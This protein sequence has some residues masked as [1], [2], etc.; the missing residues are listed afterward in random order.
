MAKK[1][2]SKRL[3]HILGLTLVLLAVLTGTFFLADFISQS[4]TAQR[5]IATMGY[6]GVL[7]VAFISGISAVSP[8]PPGA[9]VPLF[10]S[11]GLWLPLII[12]MLI[13]GTTLADF[14]GYF[15][16]KYSIGF[17][18]KHYPELY[19]RIQKLDIDNKII[20]FSFVI[21]YAAL[22]PFPNEAFLIPLAFI[23]VPLKRFV[24][25]LVLGTTVYHVLTAYGAEGLF[26]LFF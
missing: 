1:S 5:V 21:L 11:A 4:E 24:I 23:G 12:A 19:T 13:L 9:F 16:G 22:M 18:E 20:L 26:R 7:L 14:I 6:P 10:T 17:V 3:L 15:F 25:P 8:I 2:S